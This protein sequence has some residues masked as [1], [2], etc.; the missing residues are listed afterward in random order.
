M[1]EDTIPQLIE[2]EQ[3]QQQSPPTCAASTARPGAHFEGEGQGQQDVPSPGRLDDFD[4]EGSLDA[5]TTTCPVAEGNGIYSSPGGE[6]GGEEKEE[7]AAVV[8]D[9]EEQEVR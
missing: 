5:I 2:N 6:G 1:L 4:F 8:A 3:K 7:R 9:V